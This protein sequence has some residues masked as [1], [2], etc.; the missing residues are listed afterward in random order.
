MAAEGE[1]LTYQWYLRDPGAA[2]F[3]R[4][5]L[6]GDTYSVKMV[7]SKSGRE[8]Y[9]VVTDKYGNKART[10]TVT[11]SMDVPE[12]Y[13]GPQIITQPEDASA[14][15][16]EIVSAAVAAAGEDLTYQW[17]GR[18]PGQ[19]SFWRS[20]LKT[21][22]YS[23]KMVPSKSGREV[24]CVVTDKYGRTVTSDVATLTMAP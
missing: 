19:Q 22:T 4:S 21:D 10:E 12:G 5:G 1:E 13:T 11:L 24:Y 18:D 16:G 17:Y 8:V 6:K 14:A 15:R 23:V 2:S 20:S 3:A 9:C 7:P